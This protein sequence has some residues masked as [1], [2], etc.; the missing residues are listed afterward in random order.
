VDFDEFAT[1]SV[2][3]LPDCEMIIAVFV[4]EASDFPQGVAA[5]RL[6]SA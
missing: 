4:M 1:L 3:F 6:E 5:S 2:K